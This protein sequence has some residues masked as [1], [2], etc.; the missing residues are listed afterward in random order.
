MAGRGL[1]FGA[2]S[3]SGTD[4]IL[5]PTDKAVLGTAVIVAVLGKALFQTLRSFATARCIKLTKQS[6][7]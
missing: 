1:L 6:M 3:A 2:T 7:S 4:A 5:P